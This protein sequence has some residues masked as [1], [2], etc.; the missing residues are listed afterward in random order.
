MSALASP[1]REQQSS[2]SSPSPNSSCSSSSS[3]RLILS[4]ARV[5]DHLAIHQLLQ[6]VFRGPSAV[7]FQ[8]QQDEPGYSPAHRLVA[9]DGQRIVAHARLS[10]RVNDPDT[11]VT[12]LTRAAAAAPNDARISDALQEA[13]ARLPRQAGS[14]RIP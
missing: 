8:L 1:R 6:Y 3:A 5:G 14:S 13:A 12:W 7:E 2:S 10:L 4:P 11:A 9:R